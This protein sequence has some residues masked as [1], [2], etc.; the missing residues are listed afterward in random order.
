MSQ[1]PN[2]TLP[3]QAPALADPRPPLTVEREV[4]D[5][6]VHREG[7]YA[8]GHVLPGHVSA[9]PARQPQASAGLT[10]AKMAP[11]VDVVSRE[12]RDKEVLFGPAAAA[13]VY[14]ADPR[15]PVRAENEVHDFEVHKEGGYSKGHTIPG[16][17]PEGARLFPVPGGPSAAIQPSK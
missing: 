2:A 5:Y 6:E 1:P 7:G 15:P 17:N 12:N 8:K 16:T 9:D 3:Q 10:P 4:H 11:G 13:A 14:A